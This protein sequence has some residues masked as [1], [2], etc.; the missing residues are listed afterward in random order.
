MQ[1]GAKVERPAPK[2]PDP[3]KEF[4]TGCHSTDG[5]VWSYAG[6]DHAPGQDMVA[7]QTWRAKPPVQISKTPLKAP[8]IERAESMMSLLRAADRELLALCGAPPKAMTYLQDQDAKAKK[9]AEIQKAKQELRSMVNG[10]L[11]SPTQT[12][13]YRKD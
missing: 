13:K 8:S 7:V 3:I 9:M 10:G 4:E 11:L 5:S 6:I 12:N 2:K 1:L